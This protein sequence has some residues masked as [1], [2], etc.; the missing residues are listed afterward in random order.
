MIINLIKFM[1]AFMKAGSKA[2]KVTSVTN[3]KM[4]HNAW[5]RLGINTRFSSGYF[6]LRILKRFLGY[7]LVGNIFAGLLAIFLMIILI[8]FRSFIMASGYGASVNWF[9]YSLTD[10]SSIFVMLWSV[11][12]AW[13]ALVSFNHWNE[14]QAILVHTTADG[15][16]ASYL[17]SFLALWHVLVVDF[18]VDFFSTLLSH[19]T[20]LIDTRAVHEFILL[21]DNVSIGFDYIRTQLG[22]IWFTFVN[23]ITSYELGSFLY[24]MVSLTGALINS[25]LLGVSSWISQ[26]LWSGWSMLVTSIQGVITPVTGSTFIQPIVDGIMKPIASAVAVSMILWILRVFFGFPF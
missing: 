4:A 22:P 7:Y 17:G 6:T 20:Q 24:K 10:I 3:S 1:R 16:Y 5:R 19:P 13:L 11:S 18:S 2:Y 12:G 26:T 23:W 15:S 25:I 21:W 14:I 8:Y 9:P